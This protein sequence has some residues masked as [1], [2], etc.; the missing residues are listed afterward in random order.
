MARVRFIPEGTVQPGSDSLVIDSTQV[1]KR[2]VS[3][4]L[5]LGDAA[6]DMA[7][8]LATIVRQG[9]REGVFSAS[10]PDDAARVLLSLIEDGSQLASELF[11]A[12]QADAVS[13]E[14][15]ERTLA[16]YSEA[17]ERVL[18]LPAGS[19]PIDDQTLRLWFG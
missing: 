12:R 2:P 13:F 4:S 15:V 6:Q 11:V 17:Y 7:P 18:G 3:G 14:V 10:S 5:W 1:V 19:L 8:V 9:K 16:A